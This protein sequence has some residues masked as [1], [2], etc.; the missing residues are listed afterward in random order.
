[1]TIKRQML[2]LDYRRMKAFPGNPNRS[3]RKTEW[4]SASLNVTRLGIREIKM[5]EIWDLEEAS[6]PPR[7]RLY[8]LEPIGVGTHYAESLTSYII[9]LAGAHRVLPKIL[10]THE[11]LPLLGRPGR[12][13]T[14][15]LY[16]YTAWSGNVQTLNGTSAIS[17]KC[18]GAL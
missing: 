1:M 2:K 12:S 15:S 10:V 14:S 6:V 7:S 17:E 3:N 13:K 4:G 9:R 11:I 5:N 18:V 16:S 8:H